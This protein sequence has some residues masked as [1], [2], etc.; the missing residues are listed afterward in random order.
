[1]PAAAL[2][3]AH[4]DACHDSEEDTWQSEIDSFKQHQDIKQ[5]IKAT[6]HL[7]L[8]H[9]WNE[10]WTRHQRKKSN[11]DKEID[12]PPIKYVVNF[13]LIMYPMK[14]GPFFPFD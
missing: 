5:Q 13:V 6:I 8:R 9:N 3:H 2:L 10:N 1:M 4:P 7:V 14:V 12:I 11:R